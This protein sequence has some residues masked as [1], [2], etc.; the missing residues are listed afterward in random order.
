MY[1]PYLI[2]SVKILTG[3]NNRLVKSDLSTSLKKNIQQIHIIL[4]IPR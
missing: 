1:T 2:Q 3:L 4:V